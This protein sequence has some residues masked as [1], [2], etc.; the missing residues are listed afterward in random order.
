M[1]IT[2]ILLIAALVAILISAMGKCPLWVGCL[3][4]CVAALLGHL[5]LK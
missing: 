5:P 4:L 2:L 3:L 1:T